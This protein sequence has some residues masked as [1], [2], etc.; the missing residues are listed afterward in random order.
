MRGLKIY[1]ASLLVLLVLD[2]LWLLVIA[3]GFFQSQIGALL[4]P[5]PNFLAAGAFYLVYTAGVIALCVLPSLRDGSMAAAAL[6]GAILGLTAY[7]TFDLTNLAI[8]KGWTPLVAAVDIAWGV[9][10]TTVVAVAGMAVGRRG[11]AG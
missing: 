7:A 8:L 4:R 9:F 1:A 11:G 3:A 5:D 10:V 6:R 2:G